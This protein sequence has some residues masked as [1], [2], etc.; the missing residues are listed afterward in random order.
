MLKLTDGLGAWFNWIGNLLGAYVQGAQADGSAVT[1][2]GKPILIGGTDGT[3]VQT[4]KVD[5]NGQIYFASAVTLGNV[6]G[7][8][9]D[10]APPTQPPLL[11]AGFDGTNVQTLKADVD[12]RQVVSAAGTWAVTHS[13]AVNT[14]ATISQ[15]AG[16]G[17]VKNVCTSIIASLCSD[18][19]PTPELIKVHL[20]DGATGAGT[21]LQ[22]VLL[23]LAAVSGDK[24]TF[25]ATGLN[26]VGTANTAMTIETDSAPGANVYA[27]VA[28]T[29]YTRSA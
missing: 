28:M 18:G 17:T 13:P 5:S 6:S 26:I 1:G 3:N 29:G 2:A 11:T 19:A 22:T 20:R 4:M 16:G 23:S 24:A 25:V 10:G 15:A 21:I 27:A 9:A 14:M 8:D 7:P 12:G